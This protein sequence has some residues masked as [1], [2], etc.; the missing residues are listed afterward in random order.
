MASLTEDKELL[1]ALESGDFQTALQLLPKDGP[2]I[3]VGPE[4]FSPLHY[5]CRHGEGELTRLL[6]TQ[7]KYI[8]NSTSKRGHTPTHMAAKYGHVETLRVLVESCEQ[9]AVD[10]ADI[11]T[12]STSDIP[13]VRDEEGNTPLHTAAA[14]GHLPVVQYLQRELGCSPTCTNQNKETPLQLAA[15]NGHVNVVKYLVDE[16]GCPLSPACG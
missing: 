15:E 5:A 16:A 14:C 9:R 12:S 6:I 10:T 8:V 7:Y 3:T 2:P 13:S 1:S 11:S 4:G